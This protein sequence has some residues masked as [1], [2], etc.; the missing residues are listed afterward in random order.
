M[1]VSPPGLRL[2]C[3]NA[4]PHAR[5]LGS[6]AAAIVGGAA[7]ARALVVDGETLLDDDSLFRL[8]AD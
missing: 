6:S 5:G 4:I 2:S 3:D 7:L 1:G 8:V